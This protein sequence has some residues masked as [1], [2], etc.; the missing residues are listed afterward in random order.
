MTTKREQVL[1]ALFTVLEG[2][3]VKLRWAD[4][5]RNEAMPV[6]VPENGL[7]ILRDGAPGEPEV[8]LSPLTY[9]WQHRAEIELYAQSA[10]RDEDAVFDA[11]AAA[12]GTV[13][14]GPRILNSYPHFPHDVFGVVVAAGPRILN[15]YPNLVPED[16]VV[17]VA[18]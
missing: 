14:A 11:A 10:R 7:L 16:A 6:D 3:A 18:A 5:V 15:S 12:I 17:P 13:A 4:A 2:V 8:T 9:S 1:T